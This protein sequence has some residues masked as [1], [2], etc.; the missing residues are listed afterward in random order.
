M[1]KRK[2]KYPP[3]DVVASAARHGFVPFE[4][5]RFCTG[6]TRS[7][8]GRGLCSGCGVEPAMWRRGRRAFCDPCRIDATP[9]PKQRYPYVK[10]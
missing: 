1:V 8:A 7:K 2:L 3:H 6:E 10:R 5:A 9:P 4:Q